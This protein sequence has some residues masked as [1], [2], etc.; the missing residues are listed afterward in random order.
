MD[1]QPRRHPAAIRSRQSIVEAAHRVLAFNPQVSLTQIAS[2]AGVG[3]ATLYRHFA[4]REE[5]LDTLVRGW[6]RDIESA[7]TALDNDGNG[8]ENLAR[9]TTACVR[10]MYEHR[11]V[12]GNP[13]VQ[14]RRH[15][16][17]PA[18]SLMD[19]WR[20]SV[21]RGRGDGSVRS[22][23][24]E[25]W[26]LRF[27]FAAIGAAIEA[28]AEGD[29]TLEDAARHCASGVVWGIAAVRG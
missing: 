4:T 15:A 18:D 24:P 1:T 12:W 10:V 19:L 25:E 3:R 21:R 14:E 20:G 2:E 6:R 22:D 7:F 29:M 17:T 27:L 5:L 16:V 11:G 13:E 28:V 23:L 9:M 26:V 8:A